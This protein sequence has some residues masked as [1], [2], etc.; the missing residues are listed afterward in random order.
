MYLFSMFEKA[1]YK[2]ISHVKILNSLVWSYR[3]ASLTPDRLTLS[4]HTLLVRLIPHSRYLHFFKLPTVSEIKYLKNPLIIKRI[5]HVKIVNTKIV[6]ALDRLTLLAR[7]ISRSRYLHF[8]KLLTVSEIQYLKNPLIN[9]FHM[10]KLS[11]RLPDH[12][13]YCTTCARSSY[14]TCSTD[15]TVTLLISSSFRLLAKYVVKKSD[16]IRQRRRGEQDN[17]CHKTV[18]I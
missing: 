17:S 1:S 7:L 4:D 14:S 12:I 18:R 13:D 5:S 3:L 9:V 11:T 2:R 15:S 6:L 10:L 16:I 8:F